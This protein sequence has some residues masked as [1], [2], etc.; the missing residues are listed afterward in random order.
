MSVDYLFVVPLALHVSPD[1]I[2]IMYVE[3]LWVAE[4]LHGGYAAGRHLPYPP[5]TLVIE[6]EWRD[7]PRWTEM[8]SRWT[9]VLMRLRCA[10]IIV[11]SLP[12]SPVYMNPK[13]HVQAQG[14][15]CRNER[16]CQ[17]HTSSIS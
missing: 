17:T 10:V 3:R 7:G 14:Q 13:S 4:S 6:D 1:T 5:F 12:S 11:R 8:L 16:L 15:Q 2:D 9:E